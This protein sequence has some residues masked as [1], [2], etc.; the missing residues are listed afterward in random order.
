M[1][2]RSKLDLD[3][4]DQFIP[5]RDTRRDL[6]SIQHEFSDLEKATIVA[7]H[8]MLSYK[9]KI[10]WLSTLKN[11]THDTE[12]KKRIERAINYIRKDEESYLNGWGTDYND[13]LF[14]FVFIPHYFRHGDIVRSL[15]ADWDTEVFAEKVEMIVSYFDE[16]YEFYKN[17]K[18][19]YSDT[20]IC[21]DIK[22]DGV[23]YQGEFE[24]QHINPIYLERM[25]LHEKD[26]RRAYLAYLTNIYLKKN[27]KIESKSKPEYAS[28]MDDQME[29]KYL[30]EYIPVYDA[31]AEMWCVQTGHGFERG[32]IEYVAAEFSGTGLIYHYRENGEVDH[33]H[34]FDGVLERVLKNPEHVEIMTEYGEYSEKEI[35]MIEG[36]KRAVAFVRE[37]HR[38]MTNTELRENRRYE[39][40]QK[41]NA[42][43]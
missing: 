22:F 16:D 17:L 21:E 30:D 8:L 3:F 29:M 42:D 9:D 26:E 19:N 4:I 36:V 10:G 18:G 23:A 43:H 38:P 5:S 6:H 13:A 39:Q 27:H 34:G 35:Q 28:D 40:K 37:H 2:I 11:T 7:N 20:Q 14:G 32:C 12:L 24:H 41:E 31:E 33:T 15:Y 25:T 1:L